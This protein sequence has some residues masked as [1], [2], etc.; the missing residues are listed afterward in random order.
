MRS[1]N[2]PQNRKG[3]TVTHSTPGGFK[4]KLE[5]PSTEP[6]QDERVCIGG[7]KYILYE[8]LY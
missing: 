2:T 1:Q 4:M 8:I 7:S 5:N 3:V 6:T